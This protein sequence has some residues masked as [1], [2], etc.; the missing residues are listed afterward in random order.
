MKKTFG[1]IALFTVIVLSLSAHTA[2]VVEAIPG[3]KAPDFNLT[4]NSS[5][6]LPSSFNV[7]KLLDKGYLLINFWDSTDPS[8]RI[9][10]ADYDSAADTL[11]NARVR[12]ISVNFDENAAIYDEVVR[13]DGLNPSRQYRL[14]GSEAERVRALYHLEGGFR[15]VLVDSTGT[16]RA[17]DPAPALLASL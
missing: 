15:S 17:I 10:A 2:R 9:Y 6:S 16:I 13:V 8:S 12:V 11:E 4:A 14:T 1:I 3:R 5:D 7:T